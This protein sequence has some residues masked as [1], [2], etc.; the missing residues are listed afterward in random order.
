MNTKIYY[1]YRDGSNYKEGKEIILEGTL[2]PQQIDDIFK[3]FDNDE[4]FIP[5]QVGLINLQDRMVNFPNEDDHVWHELEREDITT[6]N[7]P[8]NTTI[9]AIDLYNNFMKITEWNVTEIS[10]EIGL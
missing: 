8:A 5:S 3:K 6:T 4:F 2:F 1:L 7:E 9:T 10:K